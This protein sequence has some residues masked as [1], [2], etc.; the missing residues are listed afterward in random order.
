MKIFLREN[1]FKIGI[2]IAILLIVASF[3]YFHPFKNI[4]SNIVFQTVLSGTLVFVV[5][6][7]IQLF[8]LEKV[9]K[10]RETLGRIDNRLKFYF[11]IIK[12]PGN[13]AH[14]LERLHTSSQE[15]LQLSC[16][17]ESC[18]KQLIFRSKQVDK[19]V[20]QASKLLF[21]L[22]VGVF[23]KSESMSAQNLKNL[24]EI[25]KLLNI[26]ELSG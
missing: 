8:I 2:V 1:W 11:K 12:N 9:Y 17:L 7:M 4:F 24:E 21:D 14:I 6:Q 13:D 10:Y 22:H 25:R 23:G 16:D 3:F 20:A 19:N 5:G 18:R 15:L 26:P